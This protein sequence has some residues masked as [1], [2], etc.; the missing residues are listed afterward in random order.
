MTKQLVKTISA[1][2]LS[3]AM[4]GSLYAADVDA[5]RYI[6]GN[7][8]WTAD[9]TYYLNGY[10]FV[11][12]PTGA[13][14]AS[15]LTIE[16]GTVIKA[17]ETTSGGEASALVIARGAMINAEGTSASPII[18]TSE[19]D[20]LNGNLGIDDISLWG[21]IIILG[22]A[23]IN[24]RAN[25]DIVSPPVEDQIEGMD[26]TGDEVA[27][28]TFGGD[29]T[30]DEESSGTFKYVSIRHGGFPIGTANEI[31]GLT[32]GGVGSGTAIEYV[33]VFANKD[34][35]FEWFGGTVNARYLVSAFGNDDGFDF[36]QGW[37]G[38]GQ[39]WFAIQTESAEDKADKGGEHDGATKPNDAAPAGI[40]H[41]GQR[42]LHRY[43]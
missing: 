11:R 33:E 21:G 19:L 6:E 41:G 12:T 22:N 2:A 28:I 20:E 27:L 23:S 16:P 24:S 15:M 25:G 37:R 36:D 26:V 17:R 9:N 13:S 14:E 32:M 30:L 38:N 35:G 5:P 43:R 31:N 39:F 3:G 4:G 29:G 7:V 40:N 34:D 8:T 1:I 10:H 42:H 18:F